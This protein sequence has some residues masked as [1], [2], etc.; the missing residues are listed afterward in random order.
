MLTFF[1]STPQK[2]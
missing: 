2:T 1:N